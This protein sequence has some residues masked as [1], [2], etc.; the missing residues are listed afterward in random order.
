V[1]LARSFVDDVVRLRSIS[2]THL[3]IVVSPPD[4]HQNLGF[5]TYGLMSRWL[6]ATPVQA[7]AFAQ[8]PEPES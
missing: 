2:I 5:D 8:P 6:A 3:I 4:A 1:E 7:V